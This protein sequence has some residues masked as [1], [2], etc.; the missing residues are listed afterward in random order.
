VTNGRCEDCGLFI[1]NA[2]DF[3]TYEEG[4]DAEW[5][6]GQAKYGGEIIRSG[7]QTITEHRTC[8]S[9]GWDNQ[10]EADE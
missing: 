4:V 3:T 9:C 5:E 1:R 6:F 10:Q 7:W 8:R 2:P